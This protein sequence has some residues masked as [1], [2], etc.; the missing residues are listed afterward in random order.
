MDGR[1]F[2]FNFV[3]AFSLWLGMYYI[4]FNDLAIVKAL[5][6][7]AVY[8]GIWVLYSNTT[9]KIPKCK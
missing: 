8:C 4:V 7:S 3:L 1:K 5:I 9:N 2:L 6:F